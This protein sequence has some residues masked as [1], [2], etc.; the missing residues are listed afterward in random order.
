VKKWKVADAKWQTEKKGRRPRHPRSPQHPALNSSMSSAIYN[1]MIAP[2]AGYGAR[3]A[4]WYQGESNAHGEQAKN[5]GELLE[6][7]IQ[8]W[9]KQWDSNLSFYYVQLANFTRGGKNH[10]DWV[11]VQDEMR[12][13]LDDSNS[14]TGHVGMATIN[15]IGHPT[16]I[17]P[18]NK[19]DV[20]QRLARWAF[21][22]DY[23]MK[24]VIVSGPLYKSHAVKGNAI[25]VSLDY[26]VGLKSRDGK[27]LGSFEL[28][29][30]DNQWKPAEAKIA[31]QKIVV[32]S[33]Q[34]SKP[35]QARYAWKSDP[36]KANL[37]NAEGLPTSC[38]I[39]K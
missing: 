38:F 37:I 30:A 17:H 22:Q 24:D 8:D 35:T 1:G 34:V 10:P 5:Y 23:G 20:G 19:K 16:N 12:R 9:R 7:L 29:G 33:K 11:E 14:K 31:G 2:I 6:C 18:G 13:L 32:S 25:E 15:E 27:P 26:A 4:I 36:T 21:K 39:T 28:A 3:G